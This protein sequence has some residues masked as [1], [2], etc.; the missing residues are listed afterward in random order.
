[1]KSEQV[2]KELQKVIYAI[3]EC[4]NNPNDIAIITFIN[5]KATSIKHKDL[6]KYVIINGELKLK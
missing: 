6:N 5:G 3:P 2:I 1:M 4:K